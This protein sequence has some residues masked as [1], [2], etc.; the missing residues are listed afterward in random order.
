M[1]MKRMR[2]SIRLRIHKVRDQD[3]QL[4][5]GVCANSHRAVH[6]IEPEDPWNELL[7]I[8]RKL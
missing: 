3:N 2:V 4:V 6:R 7:C 5:K 1:S 8:H